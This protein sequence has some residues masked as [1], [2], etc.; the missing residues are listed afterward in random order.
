MGVI[1]SYASVPVIV[2][3]SS[4]YI[5]PR[6]FRHLGSTFGLINLAVLIVVGGHKETIDERGFVSHK[7]S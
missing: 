3:F 4:G 2:F 5:R 7:E 6:D 1:S